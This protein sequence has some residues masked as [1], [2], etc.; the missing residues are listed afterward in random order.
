MT[1]N[2]NFNGNG[3]IL[4]DEMGLGKTLQSIALVWTLLKQPRGPKFPYCKRVL[5]VTPSSLVGNWG[6]ELK[7]GLMLHVAIL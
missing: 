3:C 4:A 1:G 2:G 5:I 7:N 6:Q